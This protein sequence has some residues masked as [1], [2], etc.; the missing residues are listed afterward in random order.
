MSEETK[1][2]ENSSTTT[3]GGDWPWP[4]TTYPPGYEVTPPENNYVWTNPAPIVE[5]EF[6]GVLGLSVSVVQENGWAGYGILT[7]ETSNFITLEP[8]TDPDLKRAWV[9]HQLK[10]KTFI[11]K[12]TIAA[13]MVL[14]EGQTDVEN[15][16][17]EE[18]SEGSQGLTPA[19]Q[20]AARE[21]AYQSTGQ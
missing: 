14:Q 5:Q 7:G 10:L 8:L 2:L 19:Q 11:P 4:N 3:T 9:H 20:I 21:A 17:R 18:E 15:K 1:E 12:R 16:E 6:L 13:L